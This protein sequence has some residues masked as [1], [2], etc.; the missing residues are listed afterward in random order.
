MAK[1]VFTL[2]SHIICIDLLNPITFEGSKRK[3]KRLY[4]ASVEKS[5]LSM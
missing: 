1:Y 4:K 3:V 2:C 5:T